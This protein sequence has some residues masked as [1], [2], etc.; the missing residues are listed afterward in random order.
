MDILLLLIVSSIIL[1]RFSLFHIN[2]RF[3]FPIPRPRT[4]CDGPL[5]PTFVM[6]DEAPMK[7]YLLVL[8]HSLVN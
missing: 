1:N 2:S 4:F 3:P 7:F 5:L 8:T 6:L